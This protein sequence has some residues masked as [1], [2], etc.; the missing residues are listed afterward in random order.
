MITDKAYLKYYRK[1]NKHIADR[2]DVSVY[3]IE[4]DVCVPVEIASDRQE[5]YAFTFRKRF[6]VCWTNTLLN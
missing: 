6:I 5:P 3:E 4:S 1:L 2:L